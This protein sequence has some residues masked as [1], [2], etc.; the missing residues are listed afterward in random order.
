[1]S[2]L[3]VAN[4][5]HCCCWESYVGEQGHNPLDTICAEMATGVAPTRRYTFLPAELPL[6]ECV[7]D[8]PPADDSD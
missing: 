4:E 8:M 5:V 3:F 1:M 2:D 6:R 7:Q